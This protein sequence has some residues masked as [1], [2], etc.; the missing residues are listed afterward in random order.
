MTYGAK[1]VLD[2]GVVVDTSSLVG[3]LVEIF[4]ISGGSSGSKSYPD[5][6]G[7]RLMTVMSK[8][9]S[10]ILDRSSRVVVDYTLGYPRLTW[11]PFVSNGTSSTQTVF[12]MA[13]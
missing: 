4:T 9:S 12:V 13:Y 11:S 6:E 7:F 5:L 1:F 2:N 8:S 10:F 3:S